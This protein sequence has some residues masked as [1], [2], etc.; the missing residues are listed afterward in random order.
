MNLSLLDKAV[1]IMRRDLL[2]AVRYRTGFLIT[3]AG[4]SA[5]LAAFYFLSRAIGPAFRPEGVEYFPF[6]LVGTGFYTFMVMGINSFLTTVQEAQQTGTLEVLMSSSTPPAVLVV[7]SALSAFAA[8]VLQLGFYLGAGLLLSRATL[9]KVNVA[10]CLMILLLS[11]LI[12]MAIGL[13]AAAVQVAIQKG[14]AVVWLLGSGLWFLTG[15]LFPVQSLP[16]PLQIFS[17][18]LPVT[19]SLTGL[20]QA[21]LQGLSLS[22]LSHEIGVLTLFCVF[23]LPLALLVFSSTLRRARREGTLSFY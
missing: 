16:K 8:N 12:A 1:A 10:G 11:L 21:L 19:H 7:L 22:A 18:L 2:I 4:A 17:S 23:L 9:P 14:S 6:V 20:R 3:L 15:A 5:E 13:V